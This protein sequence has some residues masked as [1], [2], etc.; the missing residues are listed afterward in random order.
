M[1]SQD[2]IIILSM[3]LGLQNAAHVASRYMKR[4]MQIES[5]PNT[6]NCGNRRSHLDDSCPIHENPKHTVRQC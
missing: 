3:T 5:G 6:P 2:P 1:P 4:K